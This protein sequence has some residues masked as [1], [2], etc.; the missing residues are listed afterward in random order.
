VRVANDISYCGFPFQS[1]GFARIFSDFRSAFGTGA[2]SVPA[3]GFAFAATHPI[4]VI[5]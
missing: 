2:A 5:S 1:L 4:L 3:F